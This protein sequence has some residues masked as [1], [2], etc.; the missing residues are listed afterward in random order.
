MAVKTAFDCYNI[1]KDLSDEYNL[2]IRMGINSGEIIIDGLDVSSYKNE[3]IAFGDC[4]RNSEYLKNFNKF[5]NTN[6]L[7]GNE[8]KK[9][10]INR[11]ALDYLGEFILSKK[12]TLYQIYYFKEAKKQHKERFKLMANAYE[13]N[14]ISSFKRFISYFLE[15]STEFGPALFYI[16][17]HF[18][19]V[20]NNQR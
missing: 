20:N 6:L 18:L 14:D 10:L 3:Y 9:L 7:V 17:H 4:L 19:C 11:Y 15:N 12:N 16:K 1:C 13:N 8:T 5:F 2:N